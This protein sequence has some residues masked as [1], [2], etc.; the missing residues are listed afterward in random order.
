MGQ[1]RRW[2]RVRMAWVAAVAASACAAPRGTDHT[3]AGREHR[4]HP[5]SAVLDRE[6]LAAETGM[7][8]DVMARRIPVMRINF[9]RACPT[10]TLRGVNTVPGLTEPEVYVD[11][12]RGADTCI[13]NHLATADVRLVEI[14]SQGVTSRPG[15]VTSARGLVLVFTRR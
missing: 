10:I 9:E 3:A 7:L 2:R 12:L 8:L 15:Y 14:Y 1:S 11:G 5:P 4:G 6:E 13:L